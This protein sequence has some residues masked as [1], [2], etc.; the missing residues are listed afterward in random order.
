MLIEK[1]EHKKISSLKELREFIQNFENRYSKSEGSDIWFRGESK[2]S[3]KLIP[4]LHRSVSKGMTHKEMV[5]LE[6][7]ALEIFKE[8][9]PEITKSL[10]DW[11]ILFYMQHYGIKTRFLDWTESARVA[12]FFAVSGW[13]PNAGNCR[14]WLLNPSLFN[15]VMIKDER[16]LTPKVENG[17]VD[18]LTTGKELTSAFALFP[19]TIDPEFNNRIRAQKGCF[20]VHYLE[21]S[22]HINDLIWD[23]DFN[24]STGFFDLE[25]KYDCVLDGVELLP[26]MYEEVKQYLSS[27]DIT[28][29]SIYPDIEGL[30]NYINDVILND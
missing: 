10:T 18:Y 4:S 2:T 8:A 19:P 30:S 14:L 15:Y 3:Y 21:N 7:K 26:N 17:F 29:K 11:E 13:N 1:P 22:T 25:L 23:I 20:T 28:Y 12:L 5:D 6:L 27:N 9:Q 16:V 24:I